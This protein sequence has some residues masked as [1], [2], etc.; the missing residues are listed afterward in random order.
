MSTSRSKAVAGAIEIDVSRF[1]IQWTR[2]GEKGALVQS[3][4]LV[5]QIGEVEVAA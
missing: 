1:G 3:A 5:F 4:L 2:A